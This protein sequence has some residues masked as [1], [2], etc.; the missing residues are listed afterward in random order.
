M[1]CFEPVGQHRTEYGFYLCKLP[2][3]YVHNIEQSFSCIMLSG[4]S[5]AT[6]LRV[7]LCNVVPGDDTLGTLLHNKNT[8]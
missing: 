8:V 4:V 6:L 2:K 3:E 1:Q 5:W 7:F